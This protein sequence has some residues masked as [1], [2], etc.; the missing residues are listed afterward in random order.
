MSKIFV[1]LI[2]AY[3][4]L[5]YSFV[6]QYPAVSEDD[7]TNVKCMLQLIN[8]EGEGA[9]VIVSVVDPDGEYLQ[10]LRVLGDD[11][12]WYP[13]L[14]TWWSQ[15]SKDKY[16]I[17]GITGAT[18]SGGERS[19]FALALEADWLEKGYKLR[20]ETA[21]EDQDYHEQDLE[22]ELNKTNLNTK[23]EGQGYIRYV[24]LLASN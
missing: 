23:A 9:Y 21:V 7:I 20:F 11:E 3:A 2:M 22:I 16:E 14:P 12:E 8:Y 17:D 13:D 1:T 24:R 19:I 4:Y 15:Y 10:T 18:I 6:Q 5:G